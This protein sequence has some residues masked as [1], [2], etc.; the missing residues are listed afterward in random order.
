MIFFYRCF[1]ISDMNLEKT[2]SI[3]KPDSIAKN[4]IGE[5]LSMLEKKGLKIVAARMIHMD[6]KQAAGFYAVH[7]DKPFFGE[8]ITFMTSGPSLVLVLSGEKAIA[9]NREVMGATNPKDASPG[10]IR[11]KFGE[12]I[13]KNAVH[14]SDGPET[15]AFEIS[16]FFSENE[17]FTT[18]L[19]QAHR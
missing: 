19:S 7:K 18:E 14:G 2:L 17:I 10:T 13:E 16:Y 3:I 5:I 4:H 6:E 9:K 8:L 15:A 12:S 1:N 11:E